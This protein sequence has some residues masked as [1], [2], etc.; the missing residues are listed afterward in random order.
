MTAFTF[1]VPVSDSP[2]KSRS[3]RDNFNAIGT[4]NITDNPILPKNPRDGMP[5]VFT[6]DMNNIKF[7]VFL[8]GVWVTVL[9]HLAEVVNGRKE[10]FNFTALAVWTVTHNWGSYPSVVCLNSLNRE[11]VPGDVQHV[12][13]NRV[14]ITHSV[15]ITGKM[16]LRG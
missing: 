12:S 1:D 11:I 6:G 15:S 3:I 7:Q 5:R 4:L 9:E 14:V 2:L 10:E 8:N 13:I 16:I